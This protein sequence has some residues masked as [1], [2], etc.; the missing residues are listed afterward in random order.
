MAVEWITV[1]DLSQEHELTPWVQGQIDAANDWCFRQRRLRGYQ[2]LQSQAPNASAKSGTVM[3]AE[4]LIATAGSQSGSAHFEG[5]DG[6]GDAG[7]IGGD[8]REVRR[9]LGISRVNAVAVG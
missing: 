2:D 7:A 5:F 3:Y 1:D 6:L 4:L 8:M 9:L